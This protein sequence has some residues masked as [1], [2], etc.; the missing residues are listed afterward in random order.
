M[1]GSSTVAVG[2]NQT[3][4]LSVATIVISTPVA[5]VS[6]WVDA[7]T[8]TVRVRVV[9]N[10][11]T[12]PG[13]TNT[14]SRSSDDGNTGGKANLVSV[15]ATLDHQQR[16]NSTLDAGLFGNGWGGASQTNPP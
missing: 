1:H 7:N 11:N 3:L 9:P 16:L 4:V 12:N 13:T 2:F 10:H 5:E 8:S 6:V 15:T 14:G